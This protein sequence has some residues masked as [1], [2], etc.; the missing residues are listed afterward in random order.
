MTI[1]EFTKEL[2][3]HD[4]IEVSTNQDFWIYDGIEPI[5]A[6]VSKYN[7]D[8]EVVI[9]KEDENENVYLSFGTLDNTVDILLDAVLSFEYTYTEDELEIF[10]AFNL[11]FLGYIKNYY[12]VSKK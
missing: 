1:K 5:A 6:Y 7:D 11:G 4:F 12:P 10:T 9:H 8:F 2:E 3:K